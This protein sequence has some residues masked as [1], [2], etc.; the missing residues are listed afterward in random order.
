MKE[1]LCKTKNPVKEFALAIQEKDF[2]KMEELLDETG[3]YQ[4]QI[5]PM[6]DEDV[7]KW[8]FLQWFTK[9]LTE[10][11]IFNIEFDSCLYCNIGSATLLINDGQFPK[12][13]ETMYDRK[14]TGLMCNTKNDKIVEIV[15]CNSF[16]KND[17]ISD[18]LDIAEL[19]KKIR[20]EK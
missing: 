20:D 9:K 13:R 14:M 11:I 16:L 7:D 5:N 4:I 6:E 10:T 12:K 3:E 17:N 18:Q 2:I 8:K 19:F 15:F 1:Q